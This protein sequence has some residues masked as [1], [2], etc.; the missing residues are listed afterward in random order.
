MTTV[1]ILLL[2]FFSSL[3]VV[4]LNLWVGILSNLENALPFFP[5]S[6][7]SYFLSFHL[8]GIW[9]DWL[10]LFNS[11][12]VSKVISVWSLPLSASATL[13]ALSS[14]LSADYPVTHRL[15][16]DLWALPE[17]LLSSALFSSVAFSILVVL[18]GTTSSMMFSTGSCS[19]F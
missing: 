9:V 15:P 18:S 13:G 1:R 16:L 2:V 12:H 7:F 11:L 17:G 19:S 6:V 14:E 10:G 8:L 5:R 3:E 4:S